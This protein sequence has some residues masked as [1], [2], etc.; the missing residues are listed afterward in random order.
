MKHVNYT[1]KRHDTMQRATENL[2][3]IY[4]NETWCIT[5]KAN[6][7]VTKQSYHNDNR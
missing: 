2:R 1:Y 4:K 5:Q 6:K 7:S 3:I